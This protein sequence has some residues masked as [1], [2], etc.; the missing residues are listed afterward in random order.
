MI[1]LNER[2]WTRIR[3][4]IKE[5][6]KTKPS[7]FMIRE[8]MR[9]ELGFTTRYHQDW[10]TDTDGRHKHREMICLDFYDEAAETFFRIKYL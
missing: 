7:V 10:V 9:R 5:E 4:R 3:K 6:Y 2:E 1:S 8:V